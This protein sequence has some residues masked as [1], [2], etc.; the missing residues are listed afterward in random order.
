V[1][2]VKSSYYYI[3]WGLATAAVVAGQIYVGT[4]Y[5]GMS[6]SINRLLS[7][8]TL[9]LNREFQMDSWSLPQ[10]HPLRPRF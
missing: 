4:G 3:F 7:D 9:E 8:I 10:S 2:Q 5:R 6:R 1:P